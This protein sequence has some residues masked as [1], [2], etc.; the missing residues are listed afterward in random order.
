MSDIKNIITRLLEYATEQ[1]ADLHICPKSAPFVRLGG[2]NG[3]LRLVPGFENKILD[4][5][6]VKAI[7]GELLT[8]EQKNELLKNKYLDF[9]LT[10]GELGRFR[11]YAYTQRG[12]HALTINSL[13][14]E[15][16]TLNDLELSDDTTAKI[17]DIITEP[18]GLIVVAVNYF[19]SASF[20]LAALVDTANQL[21]QCHISTI[22]K[23]IEYLHRYKSSIVVQKEIGA[24][25]LDFKT[26]LQQIRYENADVCMLSELQ[27][28]D[29]LSVMDLAEECLVITA[30]KVNALQTNPADIMALFKKLTQYQS[31]L[32]TPNPKITIISQ[33]EDEIVILDN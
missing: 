29:F 13:P 22:E 25:V 8:P 15:V 3:A 1:G 27:P 19:S 6:T 17:E 28:K 21:R 24:D 11:A 12:T 33:Q 5:A 2:K 4:L 26:A 23:P 14:F 32:F 9:P 20:I 30:L 10:Y 16:P 7:I 18:N 31:P